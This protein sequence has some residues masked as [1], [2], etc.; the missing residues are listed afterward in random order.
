MQFLGIAKGSLGEVE[1]Y[2]LLARDLGYFDDEVYEILETQRQETG[3]LLRGL[4]KSLS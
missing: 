3:R 2:L 1:T 4:M